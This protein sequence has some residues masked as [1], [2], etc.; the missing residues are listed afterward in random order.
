LTAHTRED[1][2]ETNFFCALLCRDY[3]SVHN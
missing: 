2:V 3:A 1:Q